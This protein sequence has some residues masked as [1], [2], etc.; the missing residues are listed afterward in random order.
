M[1]KR[2]EK[3]NYNKIYGGKSKFLEASVE[4]QAQGKFANNDSL[5][6]YKSHN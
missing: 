1:V 3:F 6:M 2:F 5:Q 4:E